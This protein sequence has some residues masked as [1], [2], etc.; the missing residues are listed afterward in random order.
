MLPPTLQDCYLNHAE[1]PM[2]LI[3]SETATY[4]HMLRSYKDRLDE[5]EAD[6]CLVDE[7]DTVEEIYEVPIIDMAT[8]DGRGTYFAVCKDF[9]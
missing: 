6:L 9:S 8:S 2:N 5:A 7:E 4:K 3:S 1:Y